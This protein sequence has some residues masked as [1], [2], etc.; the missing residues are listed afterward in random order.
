MSEDETSGKLIY[1]DS[2]T[3]RLGPRKSRIVVEDTETTAVAELWNKNLEFFD[4][5]HDTYFKAIDIAIKI[6]CG[7]ERRQLSQGKFELSRTLAWV[8]DSTG[9]DAK[10]DVLTVM[11][12]YIQQLAV[13]LIIGR[14]RHWRPELHPEA[15][16]LKEHYFNFLKYL[17]AE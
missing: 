12:S 9:V 7:K 6:V 16:I 13:T 2:E 11:D 17:A 4:V 15:K 8:W 3:I 14:T 1:L 10:L 5:D